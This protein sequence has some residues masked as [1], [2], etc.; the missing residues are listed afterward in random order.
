MSFS[1]YYYYPHRNLIR[2]I[3]CSSFIV[4]YVVTI[5]FYFDLTQLILCLTKYINSNIELNWYVEIG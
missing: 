1:L 3:L 5:L 4:K 2:F